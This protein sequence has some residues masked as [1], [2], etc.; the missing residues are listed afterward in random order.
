MYRYV[1]PGQFIIVFPKAFTSCISTGYVVSESVYFAP[2]Y[3]LKTARNLFDDLKNSR[4][5]SMFSLDRL[6]LS[7]ALD[8][9]CS[10]EILRQIIPHIEELCQQERAKRDKLNN[11]GLM[12]T[13][14]MP[15]PDA[16]IRKKKKIARRGRRL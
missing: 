13:E 5:P 9:K 6:L 4:E 14:R 3:W 2:P 8:A 1:D 10:T 16:N 7:I 15:L 12:E 11:F